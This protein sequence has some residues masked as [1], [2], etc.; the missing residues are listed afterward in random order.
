M[1]ALINTARCNVLAD[2]YTLEAEKFQLKYQ[3]D[4]TLVTPTREKRDWGTDRDNRWL[5][6]CMYHESTGRI[7]SVGFPK[8]FNYGE[9]EADTA[10]LDAYLKEDD[11]SKRLMLT[12]KLDGSLCIRSV[13]D[14]QVVF[15]TRGTFDGGDF[16]DEFWKLAERKYPDLLNANLLP[17]HSL[18]MEFTHPDYQ[19]VIKYDEPEFTLLGAVVHNS[20]MYPRMTLM[21]PMDNMIHLRVGVPAVTVLPFTKNIRDDVNSMKNKEGIVVV[22]KLFHK[23]LVKVKSEKYLRA[24]ALRF[25]LTPSRLFDFMVEHEITSSEDAIQVLEEEVGPLDFELQEQV[26]KSYEIYHEALENVSLT[27]VWIKE[28]VRSYSTLS[29]REF[30]KFVQTEILP[31]KRFAYFHVLD[32]KPEKVLVQK[33]L[34]VYKEQL[35]L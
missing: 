3:G 28:V 11:P 9:D 33:L 20:V 24:H 29:R 14:G 10:K 8:F 35:V 6:S 12:E 32:N 27:V 5:R 18:L 17:F 25:A 26:K 4:Y 21:G 13:V 16:H 7:V 34:K 15:R 31:E 23:F 22:D 1:A 19:I 30:A 2:E